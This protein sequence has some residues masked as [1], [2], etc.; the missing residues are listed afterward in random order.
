MHLERKTI[1]KDETYLRQVS[2]PVDFKTD[3]W[4]EAI[5]KLDYFCKN[6]DL[7]FTIIDS[8]VINGKVYFFISRHSPNLIKISP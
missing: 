3:G 7:Y 1:E 8:S 4:K 2:K 5:E 6:D